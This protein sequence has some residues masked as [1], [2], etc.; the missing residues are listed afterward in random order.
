[1][2]A[3]TKNESNRKGLFSMA[4]LHGR[5]RDARVLL[6]DARRHVASVEGL[7]LVD[8]ALD[9]TER[10]VPGVMDRSDDELLAAVRR[11]RAA[12]RAAL[13]SLLAGGG[14]LSPALLE[15]VGDVTARE[16][17]DAI[18]RIS[19]YDKLAVEVMALLHA[20]EQTCDVAC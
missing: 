1:M 20:L 14:D 7:Q 4:T 18:D 8:A 3:R 19:I 13:R 12:D 10:L 6:R 11:M 15:C 17:I 16:A 2:Q 5:A 9:E